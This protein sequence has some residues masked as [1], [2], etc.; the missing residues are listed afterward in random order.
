MGSVERGERNL[1]LKSLL[2]ISKSLGITLSELVAGLE[3][4]AATSERTPPRGKHQ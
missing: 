1:T 2:T 3:K 4:K